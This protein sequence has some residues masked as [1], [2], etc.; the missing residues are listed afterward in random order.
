MKIMKSCVALNYG[1][2]KR[3]SI[4]PHIIIRASFFHT[5]KL[6]PYRIQYQEGN[7][8]SVVKVQ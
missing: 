3:L 8:I 7:S 2:V 4:I 5:V 1:K 6:K